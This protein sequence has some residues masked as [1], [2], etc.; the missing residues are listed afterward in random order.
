MAVLVVGAAV[1]LLR[2]PTAAA[3]PARR[4]RYGPWGAACGWREPGARGA[5]AAVLLLGLPLPPAQNAREAGDAEG[6]PL[7]PG[8]PSPAPTLARPPA[9]AARCAPAAAASRGAPS[10]AAK[11]R[12]ALYAGSVQRPDQPRRRGLAVGRGEAA[13]R[14]PERGQ[15]VPA[16]AAASRSGAPPQPQEPPGPGIWRRRHVPTD[17]RAG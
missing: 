12:A 7:G 6:D 13:A 4:R 9:T 3:A 5:A 11:V 15:R 17:Q 2:A 14:A 8:A 10:W 16:P 1:Q